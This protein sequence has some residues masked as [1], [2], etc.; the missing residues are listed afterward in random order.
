[1]AIVKSG[2][3]IISFPVANPVL[4]K[5]FEIEWTPTVA[6]ELPFESASCLAVE[7]H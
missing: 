4:Q 5:N 7:Q 1:M 2:L 6:M 3:I